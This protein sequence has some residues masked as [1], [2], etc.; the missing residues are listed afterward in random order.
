MSDTPRLELRRLAWETVAVPP[1]A[2]VIRG[3]SQSQA[4]VYRRTGGRL[5]VGFGGGMSCSS[6]TTGR[7]SGRRRTTPLVFVEHDGSFV[8]VGS[9]AGRPRDP[10]WS[11]N[12]RARPEAEVMHGANR[13]RCTARFASGP[14]AADLWERLVA[15]SPGFAGY[16]QD[17]DRPFPIAV[18][19]PES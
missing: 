5:G 17:T 3:F 16:R 13:T 7:R 6:P 18:L 1:P 19:T 4:W 10:G 9:N 8:V 11:H 12:L 15:H 2:A 14:E